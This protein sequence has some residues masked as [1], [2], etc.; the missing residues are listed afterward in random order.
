MPH[1]NSSINSLSSYSLPLITLLNFYTNS[2]II[3]LPCSTFFGSATLIVSLSP[4]PN[5]C[6]KSVKKFPTVA[7]INFSLSKSSI[8]FYFHI[9]ANSPCAY[10]NTHYTYSFTATSFIFILIF[11]MHTIKNSGTL[12]AVLLNI[13]GLATFIFDPVVGLITTISV[14]PSFSL[15]ISNAYK[16]VICSYYYLI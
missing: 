1:L 8:T 2:F 4:L 10:D 11:N 12:F 6:F 5:Y 9:S 14:L 16:A 15:L 7:N 13:C 3:L